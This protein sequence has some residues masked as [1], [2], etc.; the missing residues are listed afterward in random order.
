MYPYNKKM[1]GKSGFWL[2]SGLEEMETESYER[3]HVINVYLY[4]VKS[5]NTNDI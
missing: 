1:K 4:Y 3:G 5:S 2:G